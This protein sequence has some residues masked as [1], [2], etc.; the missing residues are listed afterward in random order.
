MF[1][2]ILCHSELELLC[3]DIVGLHIKLQLTF[4]IPVYTN[5]LCISVDVME[6]IH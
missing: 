1:H 4:C 2:L 3:Y 6:V 5:L